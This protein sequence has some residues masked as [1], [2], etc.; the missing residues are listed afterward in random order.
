MKRFMALA[1]SSV[2][3]VSSVPA[4]ANTTTAI[5][6]EA[7]SIAVGEPS[8]SGS[9]TEPTT[10]G[11]EAAIKA[12]K[13]KISVPKEYSEFNYYFNDASTYSDAYWILSWRNPK[14]D[15]Y[16][17]ITCDSKYHII[18]FYQYD[19]NNKT[20]GVAKYL[21]TELKA[22]ADEFIKKV[23][24]E[25]TNK[26]EFINAEFEGLYSGN[27]VYSYQRQENGIAF[28]DNTVTVYVNS[29]TGEVSSVSINWLYDGSVPSSKVSVTKEEAAKLIKEKMK[30]KLVYRS[31]YFGIYDKNGNR[32]ETKAY[33]VYE[34]TL[35]YISVDAKTGKLYLTKSEWVDTA[36]YGNKSDSSYTATE[37]SAT[38][39]AAQVLTEEEIKKIEELK[40]LISKSKA[41]KAVTGNSYLY[42]DKNLKSY[43][44]TLSKVDYDGKTSYVW[45]VNLSDPREIN[46]ETDTD[47]YRAYA[48]ATVDAQTG[49]ILSFYASTK[50]YYDSKNNT[51]KSV[52]IP[53]D[54]EESKII[55]EKFLKAEAKSRF[56]KTVLATE[57]EGYVAYYKKDVPVYGG[58]SYQYN[59][60]N[61][62]IEYP[63]NYISGSVD[64]VTGKIYSFNSYWDEK[65]VFE[66]SKGVISADKAMEYYLAN[67]G[68]GLKYEINVINKYN[69]DNDKKEMLYASTNT[70]SVEYEIR[71]VYR[72]DVNPSFISPFTG[73]QLNYDGEVYKE[74][75]PY[76]YTDIAATTQNR[77]IL[78]LAD[79]NV[80]FEG[81]KFL[82][83]QAITVGEFNKLLQGI[84]YVYPISDE[85]N[86]NKLLTK[87]ELAFIL[88]R[89]LG[90]EKVSKLSGIYTTGY[91]DEQIINRDY[92][93]AVALAKALGIIKA[94]PDNNFKPQSNITRED[95]VGY[96]FNFI[97]ISQ[98]NLIY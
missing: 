84:E 77:N 72:P 16:I 89:Q 33:L 19:Y 57:Y 30:M 60:V 31:N 82:P 28:P 22:K 58:Y 26:L 1:L 52:K 21:K 76:A 95:A 85:N 88:I 47:Y 55:L 14:T 40:N 4:Y 50:N 13:A 53:Y 96:I 94:D 24:P 44:A 86:T 15:A 34:P 54:K 48:Y 74:T 17:Q 69:S 9:Q 29:I 7:T 80:G 6:A 42:L 8:P 87:E 98:T 90:L 35:D 51:W 20:I 12:V 75:K 68:Y 70:N 97:N 66:S 63:Y 3:L 5:N 67:E 83:D 93:G 79:M 27:Y 59:R 65:V 45:N 10:A 56:E 43:T 2:L 64:G 71:L 92:L 37:D 23:A 39:A 61:E 36:I 38:S 41:I 78:L 32:T 62:G 49:K 46:Y 11:L 25:T 81:D 18:T 91:N 73:E